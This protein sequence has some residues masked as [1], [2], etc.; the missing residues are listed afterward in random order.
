M[1]TQRFLATKDQIVR[2]I[3]EDNMKQAIEVLYSVEW[4]Q[5]CAVLLLAVFQELLPG[6]QFR[7]Q[8][9]INSSMLDAE[10]WGA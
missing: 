7:F 10:W 4:V 1:N 8:N 2:L 9:A 3:D 5:V 6:Q